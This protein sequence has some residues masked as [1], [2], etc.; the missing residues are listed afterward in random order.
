MLDLIANQLHELGY[1]HMQARSLKPKHIEALVSLWK[2]QRISVGTF[3][4]RLSA[5]RWWANKVGKADIIA[6]DNNAYGIGNRRYIGEASKA[7]GGEGGIRTHGT[8]ARTLDF[9]S[10]PFDHSGTSPHWS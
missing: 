4:N 2:D 7:C 10:S 1:K 8:L 5:L 6:R 9:E 3:K